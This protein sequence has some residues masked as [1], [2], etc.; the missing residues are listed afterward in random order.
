MSA[1]P[2]SPESKFAG[3]A[4]RSGLLGARFRVVLGS[5]LR[6]LRLA[7]VEPFLEEDA[8]LLACRE[9]VLVARPARRQFH[10]PNIVVP[11]AVTASVGSCFIE[12]RQRRAT[13]QEAHDWGIS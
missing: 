11:V 6:A 9:H 7:G 1:G 5:R 13:A 12:R 2:K 3:A 8:Q 10:D 4:K